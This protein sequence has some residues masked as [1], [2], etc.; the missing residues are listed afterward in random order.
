MANILKDFLDTLPTLH[1]RTKPEDRSF[2][3][4]R[5][6]LEKHRLERINTL[7]E[8]ELKDVPSLRVLK[9]GACVSTIFFLLLGFAKVTAIAPYLTLERKIVGVQEGTT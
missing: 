8:H 5:S 2:I 4:A 6:G 9:T 7:L 3:L 1:V